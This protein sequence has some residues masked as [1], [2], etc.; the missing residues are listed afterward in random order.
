LE[1]TQDLEFVITRHGKPCARLSAMAGKPG[2]IP[3]EE[4]ISLRDTWADLPELSEED[5]AEAKS[6]W[7]RGIEDWT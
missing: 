7:E 2:E 3:W 5:F 4:R 6:A 1:Q